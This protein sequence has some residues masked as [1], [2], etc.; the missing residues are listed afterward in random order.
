LNVAPVHANLNKTVLFIPVFNL[1]LQFSEN[2]W[3]ID[4][5]LTLVV[6]CLIIPFPV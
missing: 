6:L 2:P 5:T 1:P 4:I 3:E